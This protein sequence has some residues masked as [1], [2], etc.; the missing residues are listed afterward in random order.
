MVKRE[1]NVK[2]FVGLMGII[3]I[4]CV[5]YGAT[6]SPQGEGQVKEH[7]HTKVSPVTGMINKLIGG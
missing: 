6:H 4:L 7:D 2:V 5:I 1:E 3:T